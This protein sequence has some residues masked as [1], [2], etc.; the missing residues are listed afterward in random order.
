M[1]Y[2]FFSVAVEVIRNGFGI[3][4]EENGGKQSKYTIVTL[5]NS[6]LRNKNETKFRDVSI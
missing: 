6:N 2:L 3:F 5:S 4:Q 1:F